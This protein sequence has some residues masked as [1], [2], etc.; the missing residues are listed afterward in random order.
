MLG[1][2]NILDFNAFGPQ[3]RRPEGPRDIGDAIAKFQAAMIEAGYGAQDIDVDGDIHRFDLPD[4]KQNSKAG[5]YVFYAE[6]I[7]AGAFGNW[8]EGSSI[9]WCS[10]KPYE[11]TAAEHAELQ[12]QMEVAK[13]ERERKKTAEQIAAANKYFHL[14]ESLP[15]APEDH[16]Y[17]VKKGVS[18][19]GGARLE[20]ENLVVPMWDQ[21]ATFWG[22]QRILPSGEKRFGSDIKIKG[23][24][25]V[26]DGDRSTVFVCEGYATGASIAMAT[27]QA[28]MVAFN[29]GNISPVVAAAKVVFA[30]SNIVIAADD[31][32]WTKRQNGQPWNPGQEKAHAAA[33]EHG[34]A[35]V[36]PDFRDLS[37]H[38]TDFND[39]HKLEGTDEVRR[40]LQPTGG[41]GPRI[42]DWE[43][44]VAFEGQPPV[45]EWIVRGVFP[46][47]QVSLVA[48]A[49]GVGKSFMLLDFSRTVSDTNLVIPPK[50]GG[51]VETRGPSVYISAEDDSIELHGRIA[52]LGGG[53]KGFYAVPL[54]SAG[55]A[56]PLFRLGPNREFSTTPAW[57]DLVRQL[58]RV[59][60]LVA[61]SVDPL[62]PLCALDLNMPEAAQFVCSRLAQVAFSLSISIILSHH[63]RKEVVTTPEE[64]RNAIR[65]T[66]GLVD[67]VRSVYALWPTPEPDG[68]RLAKELGVEWR[69]DSIVCGCVVKGNGQKLQGVQTYLRDECGVLTDVTAHVHRETASKDEK[70]RILRDA[71]IHAAEYGMPYTKTGKNG[72][73]E[74]R[75]ELPGPLQNIRKSEAADLVDA[76]LLQDH[77]NGKIKQH[78]VAKG[79][80]SIQWL[81]VENGPFSTGCGEFNLGALK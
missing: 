62:Q 17:L 55:G 39:L 43:T 53:V 68:R 50:F 32:R 19:L 54:P 63:F 48:A 69:P 60:G 23:S 3:E 25:T 72:V 15:A 64:A 56:E 37:S 65:G 22:I 24:F 31:D 61:L 66:A 47:G 29:A 18:P 52:A 77:P 58:R 30:G 1:M 41:T 74:R 8:R 70:L 36:S 57:D 28:V 13:A 51:I 14:Y 6:G 79:G 78:R 7:P 5:W 34:V 38:P 75:N 46:R 4:D 16:P 21:T 20:G 9:S 59:R 10:K 27:G 49:G 11:M 81:D 71:I 67:G 26:I 40:Q 2:T 76:L 80:Q 33:Q 35:V 12:R 44:T 42:S 45:R 73:Y